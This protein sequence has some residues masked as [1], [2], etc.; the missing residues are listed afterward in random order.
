MSRYPRI[1]HGFVDK[2]Y[3]EGFL[4]HTSCFWHLSV[5]EGHEV[6]EDGVDGGGDVVQDA[7]HVHQVLVYRS[8]KLG[9][10]NR[11][12]AFYCDPLYYK[13]ESSR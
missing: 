7:G 4:Q 9:A 2:A 8:E 3:T 13:D 5:L 1:I 6:V 12:E 10:L 11:N